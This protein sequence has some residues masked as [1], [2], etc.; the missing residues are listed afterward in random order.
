MDVYVDLN[1]DQW[2]RLRDIVCLSSSSCRWLCRRDNG[3][4]ESVRYRRFMFGGFTRYLLTLA[5]G[6]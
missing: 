2:L 1:L 6:S 4:C 3:A 5:A